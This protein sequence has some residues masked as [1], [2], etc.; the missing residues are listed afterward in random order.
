[1]S[2]KP[3]F[4][5]QEGRKQHLALACLRMVLAHRGTAVTEKEL[6]QQTELQAEGTGFEELL[7]RRGSIASQ[8]SSG[9]LTWMRSPGCS[10]ATARSS[11]SSTAA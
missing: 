4:F 9:G 11:L 2:S 6:V 10:I 3:P 1:M 5:E 8:P 7:R